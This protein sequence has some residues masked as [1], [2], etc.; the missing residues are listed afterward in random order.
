MKLLIKNGTVT[1][2]S[3]T[4]VIDVMI[5]N[6]LIVRTGP[7]LA[8]DG[9]DRIIDACGMFILPG[10]VDPHVHMHL[11]A[12]G[13][14]SS[15]DFFTGSRAALYGGTTTIIDFVT[16]SRGE[17]LT[18]ALEK[19]KS[20]AGNSLA[21]YAFHVS[22]VEWRDSTGDEI[23]E[24]IKMGVTSFKVYMAYKKTVGLNDEDLFK[25]LS[26]VGKAGGIVTVHCEEG[27][28]IE[29]LRDRYYRSNHTS[30][31]YHALSRPANLEAAAVKKAID[32]AAKAGCPL[33]IVH[34]SS[35]E[36]LKFI[37][38][39]HARKQ[40]VHAETCPQYLLLDN[41]KYTGTFEQTAPFV[42]SPPLRT[43][44]D[45]DAL[46]DAIT[47]GTISTLGTDHCP[48]TMD[49]KRAGINDFRMIPGGAGG[50][51][52]RLNLLHT[53]GLLTKRLNINQMVNLFSAEPAGIF[54]LFPRKGV[55]R[56]G[57]D[58]DLV[59]WN[60]K[61]DSVISANTHHMHSDINIYEGMTVRGSP[62]Y[63]I[64]G[65]DVVIENGILVSGARPGNYLFRNIG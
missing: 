41:T 11:P 5:H 16:P 62:E 9:A 18:K 25:V 23:M 13:G 42:I 38:E 65:G 12:A 6:G 44:G 48:F 31:L 60:P 46:W 57:S 32:L 14:F 22:P 59:I 52:H 35:A 15:D 50:V 7:G 3:D 63:V 40:P 30:P 61:H 26:A 56:V 27:D 2:S 21:D 54:G 1:G 53:H 45:N 34:V 51:E 49:Q 64:K 17:S 29:N 8:E 4:N 28:E 47:D 36:S 39:A 19:R 55:I 24:C 33:Y 20:E 43:P 58:A 37:R 10:G